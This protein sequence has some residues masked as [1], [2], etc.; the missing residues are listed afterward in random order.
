MGAVGS[1]AMSGMRPQGGQ[2]V[3]DQIVPN[4]YEVGANGRVEAMASMPS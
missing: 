2:R 4:G 3:G 1:T